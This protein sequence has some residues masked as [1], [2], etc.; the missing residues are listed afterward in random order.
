[1]HASVR[2][3]LVGR[4]APT[5]PQGPYSLV[6]AAKKVR[7]CACAGMCLALCVFLTGGPASAGVSARLSQPRSPHPPLYPSQ[8]HHGFGSCF[9]LGL[10]CNCELGRG[11]GNGASMAP[12]PLSG[13][14]VSGCALVPDHAS[15]TPT[16]PPHLHLPAL[17]FPRTLIGLVCIAT[18]MSMAAQDMTG[19]FVAIW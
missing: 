9:V 11:A 7:V 15:S 1:M 16:P 8:T 3:R 14:P 12:Q 18:W 19:K 6:L 10:F 17:Y 13:S 2:A 4:R 5:T